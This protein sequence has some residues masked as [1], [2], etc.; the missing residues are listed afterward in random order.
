MTSRPT[1][2]VWIE[3]PRAVAWALISALSRP[4]RGVW[5]EMSP[6]SRPIDTYPVTPHTG[7]V[8]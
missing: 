6:R 7:R 5:I 4:T 3:I 2:G 1:R 8:D